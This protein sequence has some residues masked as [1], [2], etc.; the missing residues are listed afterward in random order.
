MSWFTLREV[1]EREMLSRIV[2]LVALILFFTS[3]FAVGIRP[4][5][6]ASATITVPDDYLTIQGAINSASDGAT[7][8]VRNGTYYENIVVNR[9]ISLI[10]ENKYDTIID[11]GGV[12]GVDA[13]V[14]VKSDNVSMNG[15]TIRG[16]D[17]DYGTGILLQ[18]DYS[19]ISDTVMSGN[20]CGLEVIDEGGNVICG[21]T[22]TNNSVLGLRMTRGWGNVICGNTITNN[23]WGALLSQM[24]NAVFKNNNLTNNVASCRLDNN[25]ASNEIDTSNLVDGK[26]LYFLTNRKIW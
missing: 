13:V 4:V 26:P 11:G 5:G 21:N 3:M 24:E 17:P 15:F 12:Y 9:Q 19:N 22:I 23:F 8:F 2:A 18:G 16:S 10:G 20:S 6:S 7:I 1:G 25:G 14:Q